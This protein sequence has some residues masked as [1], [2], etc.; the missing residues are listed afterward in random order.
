MN[1]TLSFSLLEP[2]VQLWFFYELDPGVNVYLRLGPRF[3]QKTP[4]NLVFIA[5]K[6][7]ELVFGLD[8]AF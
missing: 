1:R 4:W 7:L 2:A 3:L 8:Y 6:P 5:N